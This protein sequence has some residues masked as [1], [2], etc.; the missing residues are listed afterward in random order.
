MD[1]V[2]VAMDLKEAHTPK[3]AEAAFLFEVPRE[4]MQMLADIFKGHIFEC[5]TN[6]TRE[7]ADEIRLSKDFNADDSQTI[8]RFLKL[9]DIFKGANFDISTLLRL[10]MLILDQS[11]MAIQQEFAIERS[12]VGVIKKFSKMY[13][14]I[15][16]RLVSNSNGVFGN[17]LRVVPVLL[18]ETLNTGDKI[19]L[20]NS[21]NAFINYS[22]MILD[23][24]EFLNDSAR[25]AF[26]EVTRI[27]IPA[28]LKQLSGEELSAEDRIRLIRSYVKL[29]V[30]FNAG[31]NNSLLQLADQFLNN[32]QTSEE[33]DP[34]SKQL[35]GLILRN[36][37][38][39]LFKKLA[40]EG[41]KTEVPLVRCVLGG[42]KDISNSFLTY[43]PEM[44]NSTH[45][46]V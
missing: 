16:T 26:R 1:H 27:V 44:N 28:Y 7:L 23:G 39:P 36:L 32:N 46:S 38:E 13:D 12:L 19:T 9:A 22:L 10:F 21:I 35:F 42:L 24:F 6:A 30:S 14:D 17:I 11:S 37:L 45:A 2:H 5:V 40:S 34:N 43:L 20:N 31:T 33:L 29:F 18:S 15:V 41:E 4:E 8:R 3:R 25:E